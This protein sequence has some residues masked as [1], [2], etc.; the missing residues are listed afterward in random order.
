LDL[1]YVFF[2]KPKINPNPTDLSKHQTLTRNHQFSQRILCVK[3][4]SVHAHMA[5]NQ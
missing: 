2:C 5:W 3:Y 1:N 4:Y